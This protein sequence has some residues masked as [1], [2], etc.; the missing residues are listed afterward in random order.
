MSRETCK[1]FVSSVFSI[2]LCPVK[3]ALLKIKC[4]NLLHIVL[5]ALLKSLDEVYS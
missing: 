2:W 4:K 3:I 1:N 5:C